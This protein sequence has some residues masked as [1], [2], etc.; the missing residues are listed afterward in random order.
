MIRN[1]GATRKNPALEQL[2]AEDFTS[3]NVAFFERALARLGEKDLGHDG[4]LT[5]GFVGQRD[6]P[7]VML[8]RAQA[9]LRWDLRPSLWSHCFLITEPR[10][11][12]PVA[13]LAVSEVVLHSRTGAF[14][15]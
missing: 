8:R 6:L 7:G 10:G 9:I 3:G 14:P 15:D 11:D 2:P 5:I 1:S 4:R 13:D 12:K